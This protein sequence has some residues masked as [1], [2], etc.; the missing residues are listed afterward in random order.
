VRVWAYSGDDICLGAKSRMLDARI[1]FAC[2]AFLLFAF[3]RRVVWSL[4][5]GYAVHA[6]AVILTTNTIHDFI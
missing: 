2:F 5:R 3:T 4:R 6:K 1:T